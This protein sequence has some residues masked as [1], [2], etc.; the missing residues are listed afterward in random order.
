MIVNKHCLPSKSSRCFVSSLD[1]HA[2]PM[3]YECHKKNSSTP[4]H[5]SLFWYLWI[6]IELVLILGG[7]DL[8]LLGVYRVSSTS[9]LNCFHFLLGIRHSR[10]FF[11]TLHADDA[12]GFAGHR[13]LLEFGEGHG[14]LACADF[15]VGER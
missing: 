13:S 10:G 11:G 4:L 7:H 5:P 14:R 3:K 2:P 8:C 9:C 15:V 12:R 6:L 1:P